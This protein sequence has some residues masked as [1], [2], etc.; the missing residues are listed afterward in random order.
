MSDEQAPRIKIRECITLGTLLLGEYW[1]AEKIAYERGLEL[2]PLPE[3]L[4][5]ALKVE[6]GVRV[7]EI[8]PVWGPQSPNTRHL[9]QGK[10]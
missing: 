6:L 4:E 5:E 9:M 3:N 1:R 10:K 2:P 7:T 8:T